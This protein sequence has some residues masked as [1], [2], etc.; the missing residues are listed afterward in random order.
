MLLIDELDFKGCDNCKYD[1]FY[2]GCAKN[3]QDTDLVIDNEAVY[4]KLGELK[5][6]D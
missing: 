5:D 6:E 3:V 2:R 1:D 4:C